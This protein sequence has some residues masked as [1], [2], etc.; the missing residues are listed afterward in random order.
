MTDIPTESINLSVMLSPSVWEN[1]A[2]G[3]G[4]QNSLIFT[5]T[6]QTNKILV[7]T[8]EKSFMQLMRGSHN[9]WQKSYLLKTIQQ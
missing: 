8:A 5:D 4:I 3:I 9:H 7:M 2:N 6:W 1:S